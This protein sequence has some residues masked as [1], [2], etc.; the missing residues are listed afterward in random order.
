MAPPKTKAQIDKAAP[1]VGLQKTHMS[2]PEKTQ[3]LEGWNMVGRCLLQG[4]HIKVAA[5]FV[6][7]PLDKSGG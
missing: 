5:V 3:R 6:S 7:F 2:S 1:V 4:G